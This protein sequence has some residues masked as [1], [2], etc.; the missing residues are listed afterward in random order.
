MGPGASRFALP[1]T[2]ATDYK[3]LAISSFMISLVPA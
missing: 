1:G 3:L 2:T